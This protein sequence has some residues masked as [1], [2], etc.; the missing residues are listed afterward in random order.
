M[1]TIKIIATI[2]LGIVS[3]AIFNEG[4]SFVP[5]FVGMAAF[6]LALYINRNNTPD[7]AQ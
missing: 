2:L 3:L 6:Y 5:N 7:T 1:K 4:E